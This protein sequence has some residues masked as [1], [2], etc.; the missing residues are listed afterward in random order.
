MSYIKQSDSDDDDEDD[1]SSNASLESLKKLSI[2]DQA[3]SEDQSHLQL[4]SQ[5]QSQ[6][7]S[8]PQQIEDDTSHVESKIP[9]STSLILE[10]LPQKDQVK[11]HDVSPTKQ[12]RISQ[13]QTKGSEP[14][15]KINIRFQSIGST[16]QIEPNIFKISSFQ[17]IS[18]INKFLCKKLK[19][20]TL[21]L[22]LQNSFS[23]S[24]DEK[25][26][27]LYDAFKT[28]NELIISY[29]NTVAFG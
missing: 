28:N 18:T 7:Q 17:T 13:E 21:H 15:I 6:P 25:I 5:S 22:Y 29:C 2:K 10:K 23:P 1:S 12:D 20:K 19:L 26:G 24:P 8:Q 9:L 11:I 14:V 4:Q 3:Q 16:N 27:E